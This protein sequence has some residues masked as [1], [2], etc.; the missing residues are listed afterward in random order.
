M[1]GANAQNKSN[2][3]IGAVLYVGFF[4]SALPP[5]GSANGLELMTLCV[6]SWHTPKD[7]HKRLPI[8][9]QYSLRLVR[10]LPPLFD[11]NR[12]GLVWARIGT[13]ISQSQQRADTH[14][15]HQNRKATLNY[16]FSGLVHYYYQWMR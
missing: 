8:S 3:T 16:Q 9:H 10:L 14:T 7:I 15:H 4:A 6:V 11:F 2:Y 13:G 12:S 5:G 1:C